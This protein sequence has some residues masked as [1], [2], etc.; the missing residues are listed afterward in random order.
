MSNFINAAVA[1]LNKEIVRLTSIRDSLLVSPVPAPKVPQPSDATEKKIPIEPVK[2]SVTE[3][4]K[5]IKRAPMSEETKR[6]I[7]EANRKR[8]LQI[9]RKTTAK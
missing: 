2:K 4:V 9:A 1:E 7:G 5:R 6:K 8:M 3:P